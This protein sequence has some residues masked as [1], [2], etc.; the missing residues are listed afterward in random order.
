MGGF[1][2]HLF[3]EKRWVGGGG[4]GVGGWVGGGGGGGGGGGRGGGA[5][6]GGGGDRWGLAP[7]SP[8]FDPT[9]PHPRPILPAYPRPRFFSIF[10]RVPTPKIQ[11]LPHPP[12]P[13]IWL[14]PPPILNS[15]FSIFILIVS[16]P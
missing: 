7:L 6:G 4:G 5:V 13:P 16:F 15:L 14:P 1:I 12:T 10:F 3:D 11:I 9:H 2:S 8:G